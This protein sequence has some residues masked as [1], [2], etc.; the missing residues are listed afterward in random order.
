MG[1]I[2]NVNHATSDIDIFL[3]GDYRLSCFEQL[4]YEL[5]PLHYLSRSVGI[6]PNKVDISV[7]KAL[8]FRTLALFA[9]FKALNPPYYS[10]DFFFW[11]EDVKKSS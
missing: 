7:S 4:K 5:K 10:L 11:K 8:S 1:R 9:R 2:R 3:R 6:S